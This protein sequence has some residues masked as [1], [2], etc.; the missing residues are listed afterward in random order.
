M[1]KY[2]NTYLKHYTDTISGGF[3]DL[4]DPRSEQVKFGDIA[5]ALARI[6]RFVGHTLGEPYSVAAHSI[7]IAEYLLATTGRADIALHG[8]MH[9]A[10]EAYMGDI[11]R[12][13]KSFPRVYPKLKAVEE[14]VQTAIYL[15][16]EMPPITPDIARHVHEADQIALAREARELKP[17]IGPHWNLPTVPP[18][19]LEIDL[20]RYPWNL[21]QHVFAKWFTSLMRGEVAA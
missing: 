6:P 20:P 13:V 5:Y 2:M 8:L 12:Q 18:Q 10:H 19:A 17:N 16:L 4:A 3:F 7:W 14:R 15:A 21:T 9:D 1:T 11:V